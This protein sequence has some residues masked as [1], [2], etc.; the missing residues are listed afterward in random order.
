MSNEE[1]FEL[2]LLNLTKDLVRRVKKY[3]KDTEMDIE[4]V[5]EHALEI[6]MEE[7]DDSSIFSRAR[8]VAPFDDMECLDY[9]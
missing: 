5:V 8:E 2:V 3:C 9:S 4:E 6:L 1:E 7:I